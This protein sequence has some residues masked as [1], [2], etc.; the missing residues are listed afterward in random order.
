MDING[1]VIDPMV[2][3]A[4]AGAVGGLLRTINWQ[5]E[6]P[7]VGLNPWKV[8]RNI[9][10]GGVCGYVVDGSFVGAFTAGLSGEWLVQ[11]VVKKADKSVGVS[12]KIPSMKSLLQ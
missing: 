1:I 10:V 9:I 4:I 11:N 2:G 6:N 3:F 8:A 5:I 7:T 12:E